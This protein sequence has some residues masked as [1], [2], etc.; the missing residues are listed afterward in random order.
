MKEV[1]IRIATLQDQDALTELMGEWGHPTTPE[2][3]HNRFAAISKDPSYHT[4]VATIHGKV[5]GMI[6]GQTSLSFAKNGVNARIIALVV[7]TTC[8][9]KGIGKALAQ[10][11]E[12]WAVQMNAESFQV[13]SHTSRR[14]AHDFYRSMGYVVNGVRLV[15]NVEQDDSILS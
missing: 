15:K 4:L 9:G 14:E 13:N 10:S 3:M 6:A 11:F 7:L 1:E 8:R 5:V 12:T 2:D